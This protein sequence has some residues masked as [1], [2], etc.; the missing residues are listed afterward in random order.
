MRL[1]HA[2]GS[3]SAGIRILLEEVGADY[4]LETVD[5][6]AGAQH[7]PAF[8]A[9]NA[10]GKVPALERGDGTVLTEFPA[11]ALW[12]AR[13]HPEA[14]LW[15]ADAEGE[16]RMLELMEELVATLHMRGFTLALVPA[17]F[18]T[19]PEAQAELRAQGLA[20][21]GQGLARLAE[22]LEAQPWLSGARFGVADAALAYMMP[23]AARLEVALPAAVAQW[24]ERAF[25]R[26]SVAR[27]L[28]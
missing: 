27:A 7:A 11:I 18:V 8:R 22:R 20:V 10:K 16:V 24:R 6:F 13:S 1:F 4:T 5:I 17:K 3:C 19:T 25:A 28:G 15:P 9:V 14:G 23:W 26:P 2:P 12:I 21:V